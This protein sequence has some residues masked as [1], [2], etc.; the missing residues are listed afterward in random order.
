MA[1][2]VKE[3]KLMSVE[4]KL[5]SLYKLQIIDSQIDKIR[6]IRGELPIQIQD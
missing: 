1:K 5:R 3:P 2:A 6:T 4:D